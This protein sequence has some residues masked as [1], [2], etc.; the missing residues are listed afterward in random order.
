MYDLLCQTLFENLY[1]WYLLDIW[2]LKISLKSIWN[3]NKL[4]I[5]HSSVLKDNR[6]GG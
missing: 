1:K 2:I 6:A 5:I 3:N 4:V